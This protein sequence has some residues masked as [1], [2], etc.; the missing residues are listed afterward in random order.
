MLMTKLQ[1]RIHDAF[2]L[3]PSTTSLVIQ[4]VA[5]STKTS[6]LGRYETIRILG[7]C[8]GNEVHE[9]NPVKMTSLTRCT[10]LEL[11][12]KNPSNVFSHTN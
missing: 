10:M 11:Y 1:Q 5:L 8:I 6:Q 12:F 4:R 9:Q 3:H 7:M 2:H